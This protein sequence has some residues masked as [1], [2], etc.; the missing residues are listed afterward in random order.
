MG[1]T[2][3][4]IESQIGQ[5]TE[6]QGLPEAPVY[7]AETGKHVAEAGE[8]PDAARKVLLDTIAQIEE[9]QK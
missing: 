6:H 5:E 3:H 1:E 4:P 7:T 8:Q 9:H 2:P